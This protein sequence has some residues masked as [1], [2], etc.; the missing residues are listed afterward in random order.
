MPLLLG[1]FGILGQWLAQACR[2]VVHEEG[3]VVHFFRRLM[4]VEKRLRGVRHIT[5]LWRFLRY[6][7][8]HYHLIPPWLRILKLLT[9]LG[10]LL[11]QPVWDYL[12]TH[13]QA[14]S[15]YE[16]YYRHGLAHYQKYLPEGEAEQAAASYAREF[17]T[18]YLSEQYKEAL[19]TALPE[20]PSPKLEQAVSQ[21]PPAVR[22][23]K[24]AEIGIEVIKH[25]EG[26]RLKPY[27]D[28]VG[29]F[30]IGYG[31][32]MRPGELFTQISQ[33]RAEELLRRDISLA[34]MIV[35]QHVR[36]PLTGTQFS[37]LVALVYNIGGYQF[38]TSTL[39]KIVNTGDY[40]LAAEEIRRWEYAGGKV[41]RGLTKRRH[42][43][44]LLF[45]G[46]WKK[47]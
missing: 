23:L 6:A 34:E 2:W 16:F 24:T 33:K 35:K 17:A 42:A 39:L 30:T 36:V 3:L 43:E 19:R 38:R 47:G 5:F 26:L 8:H 18:Y 45:T 15:Y 21:A 1:V 27:R 40:T 11:W 31:H 46:K 20:A 28:A 44:Y 32:L 25:F 29:K 10:L 4:A 14:G 13:Q 22:E 41:L 37:A 9:L 12:A 7:V